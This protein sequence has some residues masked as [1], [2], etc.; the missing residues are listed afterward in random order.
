MII[1]P[2]NAAFELFIKFLFVAKQLPVV[3]DKLLF[4]SPVKTFNEGITLRA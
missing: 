2:I 3:I 1:V 4:K